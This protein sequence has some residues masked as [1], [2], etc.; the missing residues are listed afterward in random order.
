V[1]VNQHRWAKEIAAAVNVDTR[2]TSGP[3]LMFE[4]G[5]ANY[6]IVQLYA[7][8][9]SF[10][11]TNAFAYFAYKLL[12]NDTDF[13]VFKAAGYQGANFAFIGNV[14]QYHTPLD[15]FQNSSPASLQH[16]GDNA[17]PMVLAFANGDLSN[18]PPRE[19]A[20]F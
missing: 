13:T 20:F 17:L 3:S 7:K 12:P 4:T 16:D 2:G 8:H 9:A 6:S 15:N 5:S 1:F 10:P 14:T 11:A 18:F 19:A